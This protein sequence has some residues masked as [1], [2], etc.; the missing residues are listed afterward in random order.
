MWLSF[1]S[2]CDGS[3]YPSSSFGSALCSRLMLS[4]SLLMSGCYCELLIRP[5][6][7]GLLVGMTLGET[8]LCLLMCWRSIVLLASR[9]FICESFNLIKV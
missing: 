1:R 9:F 4:C 3:L 5:R 8:T 7:F 6:P 2:C